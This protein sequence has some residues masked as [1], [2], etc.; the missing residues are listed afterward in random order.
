MLFKYR[1]V[2]SICSSFL[3]V[4][5]FLPPTDYFPVLPIPLVLRK[6]KGY[7]GRKPLEQAEM[8]KKDR[9]QGGGQE[10]MEKCS[11]LAYCA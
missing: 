4:F 1:K 5:V 8:V 7:G 10:G 6:E 2:S 9:E 3:S 11:Q